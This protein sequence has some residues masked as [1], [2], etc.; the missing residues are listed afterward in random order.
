MLSRL[1]ESERI[2]ATSADDRAGRGRPARPDPERLRTLLRPR[3]T[4]REHLPRPGPGRTRETIG[5]A[6]EIA[7]ATASSAP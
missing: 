5:R 2:S 6:R 7:A 1:R 3:S 4:G